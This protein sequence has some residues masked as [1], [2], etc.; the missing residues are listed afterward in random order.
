MINTLAKPAA[1]I[2]ALLTAILLTCS[3]S[4]G[5]GGN[6]AQLYKLYG[7]DFLSQH[8][9]SQDTLGD[10]DA[11]GNPDFIVGD[12][13]KGK[14]TVYSGKNGNEISS[15]NGYSAGVAVANLKDLDADGVDDFAYGD[16]R[17]NGGGVIGSAYIYSGKTRTLMRTYSGTRGNWDLLGSAIASLGDINNDTVPDYMISA[18]TDKINIGCGGSCAFPTRIYS[19]LFGNELYSVWPAGTH[20]N[21]F[22]TTAQNMGDMNGDGTAD[23]AISDPAS[24]TGISITSGITYFYSG[25][26]GS[27]IGYLNGS[28][29]WGYFG[30]AI[31]VLGDLNGDGKKEFAIG[32]PVSPHYLNN[33]RG[34][35]NI[36]S[37]N[38][39]QNFPLMFHLEG[40]TLGARFGY[41]IASLPDINNDGVMD[42]VVGAPLEDKGSKVD[43]GKISFFS[44]ADGSLL[45]PIYGTV[46]KG[47][48]GHSLKHS[49][50]IN[51]N[52]KKNLIAGQ[53]KGID[54]VEKSN[55]KTYALASNIAVDTD[56]DEVPNSYDNAPQDF[57]TSGDIDNDSLDNI[58]DNDD[59]GDGVPDV[60]D[61]TQYGGMPYDEN[62]TLPLD[63]TYKGS[64]LTESNSGTKP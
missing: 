31:E 3:N 64:V 4:H 12:I 48:F 52:G 26:N 39:Q 22:G 62:P 59:D 2:T 32:S 36:Y 57:D 50:S 43:V 45:F 38:Q 30:Y 56:G 58:V 20:A 13:G 37:G 19:G 34:Y 44:G 63:S 10:I 15:Y 5:G 16:P 60:L 46:S 28:V 29:N 18:D 47:N 61:A 40:D 49:F 6:Y 55:V 53:A 9:F 7:P 51:G 14:V 41:S 54:Q 23:F 1:R 8:G 11:D 27:T 25:S 33:G 21:Y 24:S 17:A 35:V 42:F